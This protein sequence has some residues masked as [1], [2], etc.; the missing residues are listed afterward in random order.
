MHSIKN[1][2]VLIFGIFQIFFSILIFPKKYV[3]RNCPLCAPAYGAW[4]F[5]P[6]SHEAKTDF[7]NLTTK[8]TYFGSKV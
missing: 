8:M 5:M 3:G 6:V 7:L 1:S 2:L 4:N